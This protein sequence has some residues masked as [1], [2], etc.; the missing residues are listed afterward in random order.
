MEKHNKHHNVAESL[1]GSGERVNLS[2]T[3]ED[4]HTS[5]HSVMGH[6]SPDMILR[7]FLIAGI[8]TNG[9][10]KSVPFSVARDLMADLSTRDW[11]SLYVPGTFD[12][13]L[14]EEHAVIAHYHLAGYLIQEMALVSGAI[15]RLAS[16]HENNGIKGQAEFFRTKRMTAAMHRFTREEDSTGAPKWTKPMNEG[17]RSRVLDLTKNVVTEPL[18]QDSRRKMIDLLENHKVKLWK[19]QAIPQELYRIY[20]T[21]LARLGERGI[22]MREFD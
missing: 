3:S 14:S 8:R 2:D 5:F 22:D 1:G 13:D 18:R 21:I 17:V 6:L 10:S 12:Q 7:R 15:G 16:I 20:S 11:K 9:K 19:S 4:E